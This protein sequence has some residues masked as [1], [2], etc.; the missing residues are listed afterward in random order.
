MMGG[1][2]E[3]ARTK[4][5]MFLG[6]LSPCGLTKADWA[7]LMWAGMMCPLLP[8]QVRCSGPAS[9]AAKSAEASSLGPPLVTKISSVPQKAPLYFLPPST[10]VGT[11]ARSQSKDSLRLGSRP[12]V[13]MGAEA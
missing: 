6:R 12:Q 7:V 10:S 4:A 1:A 8:A 3:A 9:Q 13:P 11:S 5:W 2:Y